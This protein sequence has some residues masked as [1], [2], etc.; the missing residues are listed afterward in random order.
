[1]EKSLHFLRRHKHFGPLIRKHGPPKLR[2]GRNAFQSLA[3][4]IIYQQISGSAA[5]SIYRRFVALFNINL[6]PGPIDWE[7]PVA[8]A[9]PKPEEVLAMPRKSLRSAGLSAQK[10]AYL[11][12]LAQKFADGTIDPKKFARMSSDEII[13]HVTQVRGVGV[14][15]AHMFLIFTLNRLDILPTGDL[16]IRKGFQIVYKLRT[17]PTPTHME[18][19]AKEWREHASVASWYLWRVAD[20]EK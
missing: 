5:L 4:A 9:F 2:R 6:P 10:V 8:R 11:K 15:T 17:L 16:G 3:R 13:T 1:M 12:D 14:W 7:K 20:G 18:K 19:L